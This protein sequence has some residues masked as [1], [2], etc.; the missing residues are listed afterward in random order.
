MLVVGK[1]DDPQQDEFDGLVEG[2]AIEQDGRRRLADDFVAVDRPRRCQPAG[3]ILKNIDPIGRA[4]RVVIADFHGQPQFAAEGRQRGD[5]TAERSIRAEDHA[6]VRIPG[7]IGVAPPHGFENVFAAQRI[8]DDRDPRC[9]RPSP[10]SVVIVM[11][12]AGRHVEAKI[13]IAETFPLSGMG[14][15]ILAV[16]QRGGVEHLDQLDERVHGLDPFAFA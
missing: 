12:D 14:A 5:I 10:V 1:L 16:P 4:G 6:Q 7:R 15:E 9:G 11:A 13:E 3:R 8:G 2:H